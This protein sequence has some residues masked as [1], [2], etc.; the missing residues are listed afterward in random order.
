MDRY[1]KEEDKSREM[2]MSVSGESFCYRARKCHH[3][4]NPTFVPGF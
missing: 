3:G 1:A 2:R 4:L